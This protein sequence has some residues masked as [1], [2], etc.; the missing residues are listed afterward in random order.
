[1]NHLDNG[2]QALRKHV[3][4]L[5]IFART[6]RMTCKLFHV[7]RQEKP[8]IFLIIDVCLACFLNDAFSWMNLSLN[9]FSKVLTENRSK[10]IK[11]FKQL[12]SGLL[13]LLCLVV[14]TKI[15]FID[16]TCHRN[17]RL[18]IWNNCFY[19]KSDAIGTC[20]TYNE[21]QLVRRC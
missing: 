13:Q 14:Q 7:T 5:K 8:Q 18:V 1:M 9:F 11:I 15:W 17:S 16:K 3:Y 19:H 21:S 20:E 2:D 10:S 6:N 12:F 4:V